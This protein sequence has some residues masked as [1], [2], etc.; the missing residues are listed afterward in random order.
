MTI[1]FPRRLLREQTKGWNLVGVAASP[2]VTA[3]SVSTFVRT[4]GG[5]FW[6]ASMSDI[7][8]SGS[9]RQEISELT[10][11]WRAVRQIANGGTTGLIVPCNDALF[12]PWP[13]GFS[14][15]DGLSVPHNDGAL[16]GD[17]AGYYQSVIDI[18]CG[19]AGLRDTSLAITL[20]FAGP[21]L[22]GERF[23]IEHPTKEWRIYEIATV[24]MSSDAAGV[25]TF[26][27]PLRE[28]VAAGTRLEFDRPRCKMRL[29]APNAMDLN[30]AQ[31]TVNS[32]SAT[33]VEAP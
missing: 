9:T 18:V 33:F 22:G 21:L 28:D 17:G 15:T 13:E 14:L 12:R 20:N 32:A 30:E 23:S 7:G 31:W 3:E 10:R 8:L 27:P 19:E 4:D 16:F 26:N 5:G 29:S 1:E 24:D 2:G 11:L 25:I 6:T